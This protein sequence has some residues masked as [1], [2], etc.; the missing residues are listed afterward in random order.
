[1]PELSLAD[2][3]KK[4]ADSS[5]EELLREVTLDI[6]ET[7]RGAVWEKVC[8]RIID[9]TRQHAREP[10]LRRDDLFALVDEKTPPGNRT[11]FTQSMFR[12][13]Y[14][15][16]SWLGVDRTRRL[17]CRLFEEE[18]V[19][20]AASRFAKDPNVR[21][22]DRDLPLYEV[23]RKRARADNELVEYM[24]RAAEGTYQFWRHAT[25]IPDRYVK[26]IMNI[27]FTYPDYVTM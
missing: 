14:N 23:L 8:E 13:N 6:L 11:G 9:L 2:R 17:V 3:L 24:A 5:D 22:R 26:G 1:M 27:R 18:H 15:N 20:R 12:K 10:R 25:T 21:E 19:A 16:I 4:L 7:G